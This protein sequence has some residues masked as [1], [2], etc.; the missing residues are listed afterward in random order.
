[1]RYSAALIAGLLF[2]AVAASA[3]LLTVTYS[4]L[5]TG[6]IGSTTFS[7]ALFTI[8]ETLDTS[9]RQALGSNIGW[10]IDDSSAIVNIEGV[11]TF[12]MTTPTRSFVYNPGSSAGYSRASVNGS[13]L[14]EISDPA[15]QTWDMTT[16]LSPIFANGSV[17][18]W[19]ALPVNTSGGALAFEDARETINFRA[20]VTPEPDSWLLSGVGFLASLALIKRIQT[21]P[22]Q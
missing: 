3:S 5:G 13:D 18:N 9:N 16:S 15:F 8:T 6:S 1:M 11:G 19:S 21:T 12:S 10:Y 4:G 14:I 2:Y 17:L 22:I 20:V 7:N